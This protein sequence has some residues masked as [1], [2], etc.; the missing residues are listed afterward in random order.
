MS[1]TIN[2]TAT[3]FMINKKGNF[4]GTIA[5]GESDKSIKLKLQKLLNL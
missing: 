5:W 1:Y 2:H 3:V 4:A